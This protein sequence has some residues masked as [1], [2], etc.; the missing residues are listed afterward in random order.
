[1]IVCINCS[2]ETKEKMDGLL[3]KDQYRDYSELVAVAVENLW[4]LD[5]EVAER[6]ALV[7]DEDS[8]PRVPPAKSPR[9]E[10]TESPRRKKVVSG[11]SRQVK[12]RGA[13]EREVISVPVRIP[14]L[15][16]A[17]GLDDLSATTAEIPDDG[18]PE[19]A[20]TLDRWLFGQYNKL[21]PAKANCRALLRIT[22][23]HPEGVL[24]EDVAPQISEV[25]SMLGDYLADLDRRH[26][27]ARDDL[28]ATAFPRSGSEAEK[29]RARYASQFVGSVN[30]QGVLLGLLRDY[31]LAALV[32][33]SRRV[34]DADRTRSQI[35]PV[36]ES[37]ARWPS[38]RS[39]AEVLAGRS[40]VSSR[41]HPRPCPR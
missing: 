26:Q 23:E 15:F 29:S 3:G 21:L 9:I 2:L 24:L 27:T 36:D 7:I 8:A 17:D 37:R 20:F 39:R 16:L 28:L 14:E 22:A 13:I 18:E 34:L 11:A 1:M 12:T 41:P 30:S 38:D 5:Q 25:A 33:G 10:R 32:S 4:V 35:R 19:G 31:R 40:G 6:G